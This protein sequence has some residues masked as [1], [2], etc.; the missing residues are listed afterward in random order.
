ML[1]TEL[2]FQVPRAA[3][4]ALR[5]AVATSRAQ[6][7]RLRARYFDTADRRLAAAGLSVR[8]RQEGRNW[9]Q[10]AKGPAAGLVGRAE[11]EVPLAASRTL[12]AVDPTRHAGT[13]IGDR[14]LERIGD[15]RLEPVFETDVHRTCRRIASGGARIEI[16]LDT[17]HVVANGRREPLTE[18]EFELLEGRPAA[19]FELAARWVKRHGLWLDLR[20][21]AARG[22][23]LAEGRAGD[24]PSGYRAPDL[25]R[26]LPVGR[27]L[28]AM[29]ASALAQVLP[30]VSAVAG[31]QAAAEHLHQ[32]RVGLRRLRSLLRLFGPRPSPHLDDLDQRA[33]ALFRRLGDA[34]DRDVIGS[35]L[36]PLMQAVAPPGLAMPP[37]AD[38]GG[39]PGTVLREPA[40]T[41]LLLDLLAWVESDEEADADAAGP[42][43]I[44]DGAAGA[45]GEPAQVPQPTDA[46]AD[47]QAGPPPAC[48]SLDEFAG[49]VLRRLDRRIARDAGRFAEL[50]DAQRHALRRRIKRLR[51]GIEATVPLWPRKPCRRYLKSM[52]Q[53]QEA[54]GA[55]NDVVVAEALWRS[56]GLDD[57]PTWFARGWLAARRE[58]AAERAAA[59]LAGWPRSLRAWR[60]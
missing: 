27:G 30:N 44:R 15:A 40:T 33:A 57:A 58:H 18:V 53:L 26:S 42:A 24:P 38:A 29:A 46:P 39:D 21:K 43:G 6:T 23:A 16:A 31:G 17:G 10:A 19:L 60:R 34:R 7:L 51:Y 13:A 8:V 54:L 11:H 25:D 3:L 4:P 45:A 5:R 32:A 47:G 52:R 1:E 14:L 20:T 59:A 9:V 56:Q 37:A 2:K 50:D 22:F 48:P 35:T 55:Y 36:L 28:R 49:A 41:R 12:P